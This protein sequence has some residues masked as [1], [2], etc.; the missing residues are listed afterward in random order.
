M[1]K[2][3]LHPRT[4]IINHKQKNQSKKSRQCALAWLAE[5]FPAA[6]D[7]TQNIQ[8]LSLGIM[9]DILEH[10]AVAEAAGISRSKLR[11]AVVVFTRR[12]EYLVCLKSKEM[13]VDLNGAPVMQ[14]TDE[15]AENAAE[16]I[17]KRIEKMVKNVR[18]SKEPVLNTRVKNPVSTTG[19]LPYPDRQ[20][21]FS[22]QHA[23]SAAPR[24][25]V[26][27]THKITRS[28]DPSTV[29]RLKEKLGLGV[30]KDVE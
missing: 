25:T 29:A 21:A 28:Y 9:N 18:S 5:Q 3:P 8:P 22:S 2:Q 15:Q 16:K 13:R 17:K 12:V 14:V 6:F 30:S 20:P 24:N 10:A 1:R 7:T 19:A 26:T 27:V 11:E 4:A 23:V